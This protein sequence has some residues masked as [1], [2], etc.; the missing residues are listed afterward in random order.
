[1]LARRILRDPR[2]RRTPIVMLTSAGRS[3]DVARCRRMGI[4][5]YLV[6]PVKQSDLLDTFSTL[7][8]ASARRPR[9]RAAKA[10]PRPRRALR[11]LVAEDNVVNRKLV[12]TLLQK[13]GHQVT[14]VD[15]GRAAVQAIDTASPRGFD[16][17]LM[18]VQMPEMGGLEAT[19]AI[20][21]RERTTR[22]HLPIV[23]LTAHAMQG[24]R[25]RCLAAG[26]DGYLSLIHI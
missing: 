24:D 8:G 20:R 13:R 2:L 1:M 6:K 21:D 4:A 5:A 22:R 23:A 14:A 15:N 12:T 19:Q 10:A 26:M 11:V 25:E 7:V 17:V 9:A 18:D 3:D 16:L